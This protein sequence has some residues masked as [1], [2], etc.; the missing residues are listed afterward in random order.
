MHVNNYDVYIRSSI[1]KNNYKTQTDA[2]LIFRE[3]NNEK[4]AYIFHYNY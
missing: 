3:K 4:L 1:Y 2:I